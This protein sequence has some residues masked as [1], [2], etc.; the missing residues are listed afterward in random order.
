M[1]RLVPLFA[2]TALGPQTMASLPEFMRRAE[3]FTKQRPEA[4]GVIQH[5]SAEGHAGW[6]LLAIVSPDRL[7]RIL[8][9]V[10]DPERFL[11]PFGVRALSRR[12]EERRVGKRRVGRVGREE[13][14]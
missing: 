8:A 12:S 6:R 1:V 5:M 11:S 4:M 2:V 14:E 9:R 7:R 13:A 10:L 3:W